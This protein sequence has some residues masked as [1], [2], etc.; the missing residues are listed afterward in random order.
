MLLGLG[1]DRYLRGDEGIATLREQ[2]L[3]DKIEDFSGLGGHLAI[4]LAIGLDGQPRD[5]RSVYKIMESYFLFNN[6]K[7]GKTLAEAKEE[8]QKTAWDRCI[9]TFR[10]SDCKTPGICFLQD[11]VYR[12]GN[13]AVWQVI[14]DNP[15]EMLRFNI[16]KYDPSNYRHIW[17][18]EQL[19]ITDQ[20]LA[21]LEK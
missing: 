19:G 14:K 17:I 3:E 1:L 8:A 7:E 9:R 2:S 18:L 13:I 5:F 15:A 16:G 12:E 11:I 10:G 6:L 21:D 20:D 4:G